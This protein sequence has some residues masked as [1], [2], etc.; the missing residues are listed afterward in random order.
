[1]FEFWFG[2]LSTTTNH[3]NTG[4]KD[5][6]NYQE[7]IASNSLSRQFLEVLNSS[8]DDGEKLEE[9]IKRLSQDLSKYNPGIVAKIARDLQNTKI[10]NKEEERIDKSQEAELSVDVKSLIHKYSMFLNE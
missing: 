6:N 10:S 5:L 1:M 2:C 3:N 7:S 8:E 4:N 9:N